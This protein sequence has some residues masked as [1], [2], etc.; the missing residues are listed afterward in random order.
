MTG[1]ILQFGTSRFL[2]AHVDL[3]VHEAREAGQ[4]VGPITVVK[5]T[6]DAGRDSRVAALARPDGYPVIIRGLE[7]GKRVERTVQVKSIARTFSAQRDWREIG[8]VFATETDIAL[9]NTGDDGYAIPPGDR[10]RK[11]PDEIPEG[12]PA[13]LLAL[14]LRRHEAGGA[15][16][17]FLPCELISGNGGVL[18]QLLLD[19][20][21]DWRLPADFI[22]W[23]QHDVLIC[24][25]LVDRIVSAALE[26]AGAVA[27]PYALWAIQRRPG[28]VPPLTHPSVVVTDDLEPYARLKLHILNLGH[29]YLAG[30]WQREQRPAGETVGAMLQDPGVKQRLDRLYAEEIVPGF[31]ARG[32]EDEARRYVE[33]TL[34]RFVNPFLDHPLRDIAQNHAI[35]V[36]RR[37]DAFIA[38]VREKAP[39][40]P[41]PL[42]TAFTNANR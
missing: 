12:F 40:L 14:L 22:A 9:S 39:D 1:R 27:E 23:F 16:L 20:A 34:E 32:M 42:L 41:M 33:A 35:K 5:T 25:T 7:D 36:A 2:Q 38:W 19:L 3:F 4:Q 30:I 13:K 11:A 21:R 29:T 18:R 31:A 15:P 26:P 24:D 10:A 6:R 8:R 28:F 37:G 17:T